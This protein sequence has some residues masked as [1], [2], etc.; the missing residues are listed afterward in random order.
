[1]PPG[2]ASLAFIKYPLKSKVFSPASGG[3]PWCGQVSRRLIV[4]FIMRSSSRCS[5]RTVTRAVGWSSFL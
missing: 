1:M 5:T 2:L 4:R 3:V